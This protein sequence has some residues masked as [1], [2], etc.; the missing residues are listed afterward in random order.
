MKSHCVA[1]KK[2]RCKAMGESIPKAFQSEK[3]IEMTAADG[4]DSSVKQDDFKTLSSSGH[5]KPKPEGWRN[6]GNFAA[7]R[8]S[9][10]WKASSKPQE[11]ASGIH[12]LLETTQSCSNNKY[13]LKLLLGSLGSVKGH[14]TLWSGAC[15]IRFGAKGWHIKA[16][17]R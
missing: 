12:S 14:K 6:T 2:R 15:G 5:S 16:G 8:V 13:G 7:K 11:A 10:I 3:N 9:Y 1:I 17:H 4:S